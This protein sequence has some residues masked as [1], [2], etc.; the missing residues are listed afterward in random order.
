MKAQPSISSK[1][2]GFTLMETLV[3]MV[4]FAIV[5]LG[6]VAAIKWMLRA[7]GNSLINS[8]IISEMQ[9]RLQTAP[10]TA[11]TCPDSLSTTSTTGIEIG[12]TNYYIGCAIRETTMPSNSTVKIKWYV[13][14]ADTTQAKAN[15]CASDAADS[16][17][18]PSADCYIVGK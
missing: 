18:T 7:Q 5:V 17:K 16:S 10:P 11:A 8:T 13:L 1:Q 4:L 12:K 6:S 3:A 15:Q 2:R 9:N 14:G